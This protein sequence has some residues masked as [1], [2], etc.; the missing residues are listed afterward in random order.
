[1][2]SIHKNKWIF[3]FIVIFLV[4]QLASAFTITKSE[5]VEISAKVVEGG[6][7]AGIT[8]GQGPGFTKTTV[9]LSG[10]AY[11]LSKVTI[12]NNGTIADT[13]T[14][15]AQAKFSFSLDVLAG[16]YNFVI[17]AE[18]SNKNKSPSLSFPLFITAGTVVNVSG[19]F[20]APT[21]SIDKSEVKRGDILNIFGQSVPYFNIGLF[22]NPTQGIP[23]GTTTNADGIYSYSINTIPFNFGSYSVKSKATKNTN[24]SLESLELPFV[25]GFVSKNNTGVCYTMHGDLNCD[26]KVNMI[27]FSIMAFWYKKSNFPKKV[28]LNGDGRISI[29]DF[30]ILV[31][32]WTA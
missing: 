12:L 22:F 7:D 31:F 25:V 4:P 14:A 21:I 16:T 26:G 20:L 5:T 19:I 11:P 2:F 1:M 6:G 10:M 9:N 15:D 27:D 24:I 8:I 18:D 13:T 17:Y 28:D 30:S 3:L 23:R 29:S 32:Y